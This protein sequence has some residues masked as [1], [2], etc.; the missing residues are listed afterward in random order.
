M[1][2]NI[3]IILISALFVS[4]FLIKKQYDKNNTIDEINLADSYYKGDANEDGKVTI[5]DYILVRKHIMNMLTLNSD[6]KIRA[7]MN[8]D[9]RINSTDYILIRKAIISGK[10][11]SVSIPTVTPKETATKIPAPTP[12]PNTSSQTIVPITTKP[13]SYQRQF[14]ITHHWGIYADYIDDTQARYLQ[15]AGFTLVEVHSSANAHNDTSYKEVMGKALKKLSQYGLKAVVK[16]NSSIS[17]SA[18]DAEREQK[19]R[20]MVS[21]YSKYPN[22]VEYFISD[23]PPDK[24]YFTNMGRLVNLIHQLDPAAD[25]V[26]DL[27]P[28][29]AQLASDYK[30]DYVIPFAQQA[31]TY[32][33]YFDRYSFQ[34][35]AGYYSNLRDIYS[36]SEQY[37]KIPAAIILLTQHGG[38]K[39]VTKNEIAFQVS[40][41]LAFGMK[42]IS[43]FT[44]SVDG[45]QNEG[46]TNAFLDVNHNRTQHYYDVQS[47]NKWLIKLGNQLFDKKNTGIY[48]FNES[49]ITS[50]N[51]SSLTASKAGLVSMFDDNSYMLV[52][53]EIVNPTNNT[54]TFSSMSGMSYFNTDN[55]KWTNIS[56]NVNN[57]NFAINSS[58]NQIVIYPGRC[59]LLKGGNIWKKS[60][61]KWTQDSKG[62]HYY[63]ENGNMVKNDWVQYEDQWYHFNNDG[64]MQKGWQQL[65][66]SGG[67]YWFY[68]ADATGAMLRNGCFNLMYNNNESKFCFNDDG[69]CTSGYGCGSSSGN[70]S[71]K[72]NGWVEDSGGWYYYENGNI[73]KNGWCQYGND[74]YYAGED[75]RMVKN[76]WIQHNGKWCY[77]GADGVAYMNK[78]AIIDGV[79]YHFDSNGYCDSTNCL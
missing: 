72:K 54:F 11:E 21:T 30:N 24:T 65:S 78:I 58:T 41:C 14:E 22:V 6:V 53:T 37:N 3:V 33:I 4:L 1:K 17:F 31:N 73:K 9:N 44:Y 28:K 57:E 29:G 8:G 18:N 46:Y 34:D 64:I 68:F 43:Y 2:K 27:L 60:N 48:G 35:K 56:G 45:I 10:F 51:N 55:G 7:D 15:E 40:M 16:T 67:N 39:N 76:K 26:I 52:N 36:V 32:T 59:I 71:S 69:I 70:S 77:L 63:D 47:V 12:T 42:R 61:A 25:G 79:Q 38:L 13:K 23:E 20:D 5:M 74:W 50:Y 75:G 66:W 49:S 19:V 62:W